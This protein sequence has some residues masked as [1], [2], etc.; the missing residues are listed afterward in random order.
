MQFITV[1]IFDRK[2]IFLNW[3]RLQFVAI[4]Q[5]P[6]PRKSAS[7]NSTMNPSHTVVVITLTAAR[8]VA[9][10]TDEEIFPLS[11]VGY[12]AQLRVVIVESFAYPPST[13]TPFFMEKVAV[14]VVP[15]L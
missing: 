8:I 12:K 13:M 3:R 11:I 10:L 4:W 1:P 9:E 2:R 15:G 5:G 14:D 7:P 6:F